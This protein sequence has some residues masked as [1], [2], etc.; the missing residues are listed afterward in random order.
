MILDEVAAV[1][2]SSI[3]AMRIAN[4]RVPDAP[5]GS[6]PGRKTVAERELL[7]VFQTETTVSVLC[8][9]SHGA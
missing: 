6:I 4:D 8:E 5:R 9:W 1:P 3:S 2:P 7:V